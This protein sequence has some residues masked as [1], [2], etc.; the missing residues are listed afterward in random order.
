MTNPFNSGPIAPER[1]PPINPQYFQ[2]SAFD[3]SALSYGANTT[4]TTSVNNNYVI[5]QTVRLVIPFAFGAQQLNGQQGQ[6]ISIPAADQVVVNINSS[7]TDPFN[8]SSTTFTKPQI[9]AIGDVNSGEIS[10]TARLTDSSVTG[11][12]IPGT[13]I[14]ISP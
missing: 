7:Q 4:V 14:N 6:V 2:P 10:S 1:N 5:G 9:M 13:F 8:S 3:I 11:P 12:T